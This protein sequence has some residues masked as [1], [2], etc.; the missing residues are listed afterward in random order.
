MGDRLVTINMRRKEGVV[1]LPLSGGWVPIKWVPI[2]H[3]V[4]WAK[5]YLP[6]KWHLDLSSRLVTI[7]E[8]K[9]GGCYPLLGER[10]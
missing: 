6:T 3:N 4:A 2:K 1:P 5:V 9:V 10:S 7:H 8:P